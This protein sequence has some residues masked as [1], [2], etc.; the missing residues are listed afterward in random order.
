MILPDMES[1]RMVGDLSETLEISEDTLDRGV[2]EMF[3]LGSPADCVETLLRFIRA[4]ATH[5]H[6]TT[7]LPDEE[8]YAQVSKQI[9][10]F[11]RK[12]D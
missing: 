6:I 5:I 10:P 1:S 9:I 2:E 11:I 7:F 8:N 4:G 12:R 3:A